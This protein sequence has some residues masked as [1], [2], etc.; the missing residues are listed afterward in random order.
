MKNLSHFGQVWILIWKKNE[1]CSRPSCPACP[2]ARQRVHEE[3]RMAAKVTSKCA[4]V[5]PPPKATGRP[6]AAARDARAAAAEHRGMI[7]C[8]AVARCA[9]V[10]AVLRVRED[11]A[12][13]ASI[14]NPQATQARRALRTSSV[15][16]GITSSAR[17][18]HVR[19][20]GRMVCVPLISRSR[21]REKRRVRGTPRY[22]CRG[23][24][25][26]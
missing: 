5:C 7:A 22:P 3:C 2:T 19:R 21:E 16:T 4:S 13:I 25:P 20:V 8:R 9:C 14:D 24:V 18:H 10:V 26:K 15:S 6:L 1:G 17:P 11:P 23:R 12:R